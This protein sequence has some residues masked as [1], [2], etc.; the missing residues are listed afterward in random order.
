MLDAFCFADSLFDLLGDLRIDLFRLRSL[1]GN[2]Y[3]NITE[4]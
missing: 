2:V 3:R 4:T 1:I